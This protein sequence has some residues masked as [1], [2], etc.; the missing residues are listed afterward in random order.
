MVIRN[1]IGYCGIKLDKA[2]KVL[3]AALTH[4]SDSWKVT[5]I[6]LT[7]SPVLF[8]PSHTAPGASP[9]IPR[10]FVLDV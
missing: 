5:V 3:S 4:A 1:L 6:T 2:R 9:S 8:P 10:G 7:M